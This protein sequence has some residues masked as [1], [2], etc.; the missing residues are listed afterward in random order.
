MPE[1]LVGSRSMAR[2]LLV[3][4]D[5]VL[6]EDLGHKLRGWGHEIDLASD[7]S[8]AYE[9]IDRGRPQ[10]ILS[11]ISLPSGSGFD[12]LRHVGN[13]QFGLVETPVILISAIDDKAS[14]LY[15][16]LCGAVDYL[17]KPVDY[18]VLKELID[19]RL[20]GSR[21]WW[22]RTLLSEFFML[23]TS[24]RGERKDPVQ[25]SGFGMRR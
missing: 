14:I 23:R 1:S 5:G 3:E 21:S 24:R 9:A 7:L 10:L 17:I 22:T 25:R 4:D 19:Q 20:Q 16:E 15:G 18:E 12:L 11:D 8:A 6:S 2:I 13:R